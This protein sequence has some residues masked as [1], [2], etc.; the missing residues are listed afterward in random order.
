MTL[1]LTKDF[2]TKRV[3]KVSL[4]LAIMLTI[5]HLTLLGSDAPYINS[6]ASWIMTFFAPFFACVGIHVVVVM[7]KKFWGSKAPGEM[8]NAGGGD[9]MWNIS[10]HS[11][12]AFLFMIVLT[13]TFPVVLLL[14]P[15]GALFGI[16]Y[17]KHTIWDTIIH[18]LTEYTTKEQIFV[19]VI[20]LLLSIGIS[21]VIW[22]ILIIL[23]NAAKKTIVWT[24]K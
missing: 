16:A 11:I 10:G 1:L 21:I 7:Y 24:W 4:V 3:L 9:L 5:W 19:G 2:I 13:L 20:A 23:I 8:I 17:Y 14:L 6:V 15:S 12:E 22:E 18:N